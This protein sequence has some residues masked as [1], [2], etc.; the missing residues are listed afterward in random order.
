MADIHTLSRSSREIRVDTVPLA[1]RLLVGLA[2]IEPAPG[3][4]E[5]HWRQHQEGSRWSIV[6]CLDDRP[7]GYASLLWNRPPEIPEISDLLVSSTC[8]RSGVGATLLRELESWVAAAGHDRLRLKLPLAA[9]WS[10]IRGLAVT[11]GYLPAACGAMY[12]GQPV[13]TGT[14]ITVDDRLVLPV[15]KRLAART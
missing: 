1:E 2:F 14:T 15:E 11:L 3:R 10:A 9:E 4:W 13:M 12:D 6:A 5:T 7:V 8:R